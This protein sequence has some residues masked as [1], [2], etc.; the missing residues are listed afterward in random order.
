MLIIE[1]QHDEALEEASRADSIFLRSQ[2]LIKQKRFLAKEVHEKSL[3]YLQRRKEQSA[4][5]GVGLRQSAGNV[6]SPNSTQ[7]P[8]SMEADT[9]EWFLS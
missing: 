7:L 5:A 4:S 3:A 9:G 2:E 1:R 6:G 8:S